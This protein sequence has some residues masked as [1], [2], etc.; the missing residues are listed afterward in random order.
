M[1]G[2]WW[3]NKLGAAPRAPAPMPGVPAT[4]PYAP[5]DIP[6][7]SWGAPQQQLVPQQAPQLIPGSVA[8]DLQNRYGATIWGWKGDMRYGAGETAMTGNCPG[9][10]STRFFSKKSGAITTHNGMAYPRPECMD[11]GYPQEQG[12]LDTATVVRGPA[13]AARQDEAV[14]PAGTLASLRPH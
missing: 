4:G 2:N 12:Y 10:G 7:Q 3:A 11:C 13:I 8:E 9:C 1:A 6:S 5:T 14:A